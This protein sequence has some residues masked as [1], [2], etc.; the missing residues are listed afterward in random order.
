[1]SNF[2]FH[3]HDFFLQ[4]FAGRPAHVVHAHRSS[5]NIFFLLFELPFPKFGLLF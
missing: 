4:G 2:Q 1:L 3:I 5:L